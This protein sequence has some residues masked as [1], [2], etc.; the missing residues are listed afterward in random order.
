MKVK[1]NIIRIAFL[2]TCSLLLLQPLAASV[3]DD[4]KHLY[5]SDQEFSIQGA[6]ELN[7]IFRDN[8]GIMY[9]P[10]LGT[11]PNETGEPGIGEV[12]PEPVPLQEGFVFFLFAAGFYIV[13]KLRKIVKE[14]KF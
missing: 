10:G 4:R 13:C 14:M 2:L 5:N 9:L 11:D 6:T 7:Q 3:Y 12:T 1:N 8:S